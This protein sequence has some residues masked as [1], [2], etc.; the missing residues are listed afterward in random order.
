MIRQFACDADCSDEHIVQFLRRMHIEDFCVD[1]IARLLEGSALTQ[2]GCPPYLHRQISQLHSA[3]WFVL[4]ND[5]EVVRTERGTRPG[6]GFAD[7]IWSLA[8]ARWIH[9]M[10]DRLRSSGAFPPLLWNQEV[11]IKTSVGETEIPYAL[12]AWADDVVSL[13]LDEDPDQLIAKLEFTCQTMVEELLTYGLLPNFSGGKTEAVVDPRGAG[14]TQVRRHIFTEGKGL[15]PIETSLPDQPPLKIVPK[16]K[17][18]GG[19]IT[20]GAKMRPEIAARAALRV[21]RPLQSTGTR[22]TVTHRL[23]LLRGSW[24]CRLPLWLHCTTGQEHGQS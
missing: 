24:Y 12:V 9:R 19:I 23:I 20:H 1:D 14:S 8:F 4:A 2:Q 10:E 17:H 3:T 11:G 22:S 18:L 7:A 13:G 16:Y 6:D 15:L 5:T 21:Y